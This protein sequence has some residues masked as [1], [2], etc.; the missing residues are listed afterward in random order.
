[1]VGCFVF[2]NWTWLFYSLF[3]C[4]IVKKIVLEKSHVIKLYKVTKIKGCEETIVH[5]HILQCEWQYYPHCFSFF[6]MVFNFCYDI[7]FQICFYQFYL[8]ILGWLR[9][10]LHNFFRF[11]LPFYKVSMVCEFT[12]VTRVVMVYEFGGCFFFNWSWLFYRLLFSHIVKK[13][14]LEKK[15]LLNFIKSI[16]L[17]TCLIG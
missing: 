11:I 2:F 3:F 13:I 5:S 10:W 8:L 16:D 15:M 14:V 17:F 7:F 12:R 9:I 1:L 6:F 4:H